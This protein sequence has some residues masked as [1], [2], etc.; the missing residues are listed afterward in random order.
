MQE[1]LDSPVTR[2]K[3]YAMSI[4]DRLVLGGFSFEPPVLL[5]PM[6]GY[7][8]LAFRSS[9][10]ALGGVGLAYTEMLSPASLLQGKS[11]RRAALLATDDHD[12]PIGYQIYGSRPETLCRAARWLEENGARLID[13]N[14]GCP[15]RKISHHGAG[16]GLLRDPD[17]AV[18]I[19]AQVVLTVK[20]P[21][22]V[23]LRLGW[24]H[25]RLVAHEMAPAL[26]EAGVAAVTIHGRTRGQ[27][28]SGQAD[29][30][31]IARVVRSV[32]RIPVIGNGDVTSPETARAMFLKTGC[33]AIMIG[34]AAL[35]NPWVIRD[36]SRDLQGLPPDPP[37][38][39]ADKIQFMK[40][41]FEKNVLL[42]GPKGG[43]LLFRK[44]I[45]L[46]VR[47]LLS[48]RPE[49]VEWLQLDDP[50]ELRRRMENLPP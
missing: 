18:R 30:A 24:D 42:Y 8:D 47:P 35:S 39:R 21:V 19:A 15:Q 48:G 4:P 49:M 12:Q 9:I 32:R 29:I 7:S 41:H 26:E 34:R 36:V 5:A 25:S 17:A 40:D 33:A 50:D 10:R 43:T 11:R 37:P 45:P 22:T 46:Y 13:I 1:P 44:W 23:K 3:R 20:I 28:Y 31:E 27:G 38:S 14:M 16:A 2:E 6:A